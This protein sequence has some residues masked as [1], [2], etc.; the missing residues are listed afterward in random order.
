MFLVS[1]NKEWLFMLVGMV[2]LV[3]LRKV[4]RILCNFMGV[5]VFFGVMWLVEG[6]FMMYGI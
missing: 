3:V 1:G 2:I 4:G 6:Y 5:F